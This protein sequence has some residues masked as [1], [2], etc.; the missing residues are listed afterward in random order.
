MQLQLGR[1]ETANLQ[2]SYIANQM[3]PRLP[4]CLF[5][6]IQKQPPSEVFYC[7]FELEQQYWCTE[8][9]FLETSHKIHKEN[10]CARV[11]FLKFIKKRL[12]NSCFP[13][14]CANFLRPPLSQ[15]T[16]C[17][18]AGDC[19]FFLLIFL[20]PGSFHLFVASYRYLI[21]CFTTQLFFMIAA[22]IFPVFYFL[23]LKLNL[24]PALHLCSVL[25]FLLPTERCQ[26]VL[27]IEKC[28]TLYLRLF[29]ARQNA[30]R[31]FR[32]ILNIIAFQH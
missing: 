3:M 2:Y 16:S 9:V 19:C 5:K 18:L 17:S 6:C 15:N 12:W 23:F 21:L 24:F 26:T 1:E 14:N 28:E 31:V 8:K 22:A 32:I 4:S 25:P 29:L 27:L 13:V 11:S 7:Q 10:T 20:L 30:T